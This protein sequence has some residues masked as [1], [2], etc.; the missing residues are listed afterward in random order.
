MSHILGK[1][2]ERRGGGGE[3]RETERERDRGREGEREGEGVREGE[4]GLTHGREGGGGVHCKWHVLL[5]GGQPALN[6]SNV[7]VK[8]CNN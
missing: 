4:G 6:Q 2:R 5:S 1:D 8:T 3:E 7:C